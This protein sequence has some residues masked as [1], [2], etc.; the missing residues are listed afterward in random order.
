[1]NILLAT[2]LFIISLIS[3]IWVRIPRKDFGVDTWYFLN[4]AQAFRKSRRLPARLDNYLL[5]I[6]EQWYPPFLAFIL[7]LFSKRITDKYH[8]AFSAVIDSLQT[9]TLYIFTLIL[10]SRTDIAILAALLYIGSSFNASMASNLNARPLAS[11]IFSFLMLA[12]YNFINHPAGISLIIVSVLG[13]VL[14]HTH[15]MATQQFLIMAVGLTVLTHD[16]K[17]ILLF[18]LVVICSLAATGG[19]YFKILNNNIQIV[20]FWSRN[21]PYAFQHQ[22]YR[23]DIYRNIK[24]SNSKI[25]VSGLKA[26]KLMSMVAR[27]QLLLSLLIIIYFWVTHSNILYINNLTFFFYWVC[28]NYFTVIATT[29]FPVFKYIGEGFKYLI[30]GSFP[31]SFLLTYGIFSIF[32]SVPAVAYLIIFILMA[33]SF[34]VQFFTL[35]RQRLNTN[36]FV[37]NEFKKVMDILKEDGANNIICLPVSKAEPVA[38]LSNKKVLWGAHG[39]GWDN[40]DEFWPVIKVPIEK[41]IEKYKIGFI[42]L[43]KRFVDM[44]DLKINSYIEK[45]IF[46]GVNYLLVRVKN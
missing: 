22:I 12:V 13:T 19:F 35:S 6:D 24:K 32:S 37:D 17:F 23:S 39:S 10:T 3:R 43:D 9:I 33:M 21:I 8:W 36:A 25:G 16:I 29:Y 31:V 1:M 41:L 42:L 44:G 40:L 18:I 26:H 5:D 27:L 20:K 2:G 30:F 38:Y 15:K 7:S 14:L 34:C 45:T 46:E 4:Y 11:L 28:I